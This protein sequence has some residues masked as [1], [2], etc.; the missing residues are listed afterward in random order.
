MRQLNLSIVG[1]SESGD[2]LHLLSKDLNKEYIQPVNS[3]ISG[4]MFDAVRVPKSFLSVD[5]HTSGGV[6]NTLVKNITQSEFSAVVNDDDRIVSVIKPG[7]SWVEDEMYLNLV[8]QI[9]E[10]L[11]QQSMVT[12]SLSS[13]E[14]TVQWFRNDIVFDKDV[15]KYGIQLSRR[16]EGGVTA[17]TYLERLICTNGSLVQDKQAQVIMTNLSPESFNRI[18]PLLSSEFDIQRYLNFLFKYKGEY[19]KATYKEFAVIKRMF[20]GLMSVDTLEEYFPETEMRE[21]YQSRGIDILKVDDGTRK[22][23]SSGYDLYDLYNVATNLI[24]NK[25]LNITTK[26]RVEIFNQF[27]SKSGLMLTSPYEQFNSDKGLKHLIGN[28]A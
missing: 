1:A 4:D 25:G 28:A 19:K 18:D 15:F 11:Q 3:K 14:L 17:H 21:F 9:S 2:K 7:Y 16:L 23:L 12:K 20:N 8:N 26:S 27:T 13:N 10:R 6:L 22:K 24:S 5:N